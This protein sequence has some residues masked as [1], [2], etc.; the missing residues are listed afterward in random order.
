M[1]RLIILS[2]TTLEWLLAIVA[3]GAAL[4]GVGIGVALAPVMR[5]LKGRK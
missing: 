5:W 4:L 1:G 3:C 2:M